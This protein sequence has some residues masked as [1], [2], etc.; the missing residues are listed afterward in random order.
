MST[1]WDGAKFPCP[2]YGEYFTET[3]LNSPGTA[4][5]FQRNACS[6]SPVWLR[7]PDGICSK[8]TV[9]INL[10]YINDVNRLEQKSK[11]AR[12]CAKYKK[13]KQ[14][15]TVQMANKAKITKL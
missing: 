3:L 6:T 7:N 9:V 2:F 1:F 8:P 10:P 13:K 5:Q 12:R 11:N 4:A 15:S 14:E